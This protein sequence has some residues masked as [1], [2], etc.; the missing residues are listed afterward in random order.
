MN[1]IHECNLGILHTRMGQRYSN[2]LD[3]DHMLKRIRLLS[4][5]NQKPTYLDNEIQ[6]T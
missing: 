4:V 3:H 5:D 1:L 6:G 2:M